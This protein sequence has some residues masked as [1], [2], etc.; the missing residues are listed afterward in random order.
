MEH[1]NNT[2]P[3]AGSASPPVPNPFYL[4]AF[5]RALPAAL[6]LA[7][8]ALIPV[9]IDIPTAVTTAIG[10][11]S[12][13]QALRD[14]I[15]RELPSFDI[16]SFD[17][18]ETYVLATAHA[19]ALYLAA[20]APPEA[21][22]TL[23]EEGWRVR[24]TLH[25]DAVALSNRGLINGDRLTKLK[26]AVGYKNLAFD[27]VGLAA[28][29][30]AS[31]DQI[32]GKTALQLTELDRAEVLGEQLIKA[33][34]V[35]EKSPAIATEVSQQRQRVFTLF[36]RAYDQVRRAVSFLH[37]NEGVVE[38]LA[39]SLYAGRGARRK[40]DGA[41]VSEGSARDPKEPANL[42]VPVARAR[43]SSRTTAARG[44]S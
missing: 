5:E 38:E 9:N 19:H 10:K 43:P 15:V 29:L 13:L 2:H 39:P 1:S 23:T 25:S 6:A 14:R 31:W 18:L 34:S 33:L 21:L 35:R 12:A 40:A 3:S 22:A 37:W 20:S 32:A 41:P 30:R 36:V 42:A 7:P 44:T 27:L 8:S 26:T 4:D 16:S 17:Q 11:L 28:L 24:D